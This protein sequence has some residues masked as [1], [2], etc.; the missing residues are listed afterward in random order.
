ML[1]SKDRREQ[2]PRFYQPQSQYGPA[3]MRIKSIEVD[4]FKSLVDFKI[5][6]AKFVAG[7]IG[8][9]QPDAA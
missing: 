3:V 5:E 2:I 4:N 7:E 6:L 9:G 8:H 1:A